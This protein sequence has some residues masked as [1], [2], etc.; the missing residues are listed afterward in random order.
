MTK[1]TGGSDGDNRD[2]NPEGTTTEFTELRTLMVEMQ[3]A[4]QVSSQ[5][6]QA[7]AM[8]YPFD[9]DQTYF[10]SLSWTIMVSFYPLI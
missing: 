8:P 9:L 10:W 7:S 2:Q 3:T 4:T 6:T 1:K 5:V